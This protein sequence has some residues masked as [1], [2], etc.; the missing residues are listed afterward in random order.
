MKLF[1]KNPCIWLV[2]KQGKLYK[3]SQFK[4][5]TQ[6]LIKYHLYLFKQTIPPNTQYTII[7]KMVK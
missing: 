1:E 5:A 4:K 6:K 7:H 3:F 2:Q